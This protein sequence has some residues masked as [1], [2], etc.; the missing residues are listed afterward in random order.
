MKNKNKKPVPDPEKPGVWCLIVSP[1]DSLLPPTLLLY[2]HFYWLKIGVLRSGFRNRLSECWVDSSDPDSPTPRL[3]AAVSWFRV[4][5]FRSLNILENVLKS[6]NQILGCCLVKCI[7][8]VFPVLLTT[9]LF[10]FIHFFKD[11]SVR[12][13]SELNLWIKVWIKVWAS[14]LCRVF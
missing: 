13:G 1:V 10:F 4:F 9:G 12:N 3:L 14:E 8:G 2:F 7:V 11:E 5:F 6:F